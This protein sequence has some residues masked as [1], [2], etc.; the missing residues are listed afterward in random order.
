[1]NSRQDNTPSLWKSKLPRPKKDGHKYDRGHGIVIGGETM[2]GAACLA[3]EA[4]M[5]SGSVHRSCTAL[6]GGY[7]PQLRTLLN[8]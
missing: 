3:A 6:C 2:T 8:Y 5:R 4:M 7:L 1:M